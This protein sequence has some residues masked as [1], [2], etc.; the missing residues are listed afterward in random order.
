LSP[1]IPGSKHVLAS[2]IKILALSVG[3]NMFS[4]C[5]Q[6]QNHFPKFGILTVNKIMVEVLDIKIN[7]GAS[8]A[9]YLEI[10]SYIFFRQ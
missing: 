6:R 8:S 2:V 3:Q 7:C 10:K 4:F 1:V 9:K 5:L